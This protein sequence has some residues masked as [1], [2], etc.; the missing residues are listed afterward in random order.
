MEEKECRELEKR[1]EKL[2]SKKTLLM[3]LDE[4]IPWSEFRPLLEQ[5]HDKPRKSKVR[6]KLKQ[7]GL[8]EELFEQFDGYLRQFG[9]QAKGGQ[10]VDATLIPVPKQHNS[11]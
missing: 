1:Y 8:I 11:K 3:R 5:I 4:T 7:Q 2:K 6:H 10:I 9:Y